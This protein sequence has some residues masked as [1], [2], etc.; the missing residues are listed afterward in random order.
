MNEVLQELKSVQGVSGVLVL[1][2]RSL[3]VHRLLPAYFSFDL[4]KE[5]SWSLKDLV[6]LSQDKINFTF[7]FENGVALV[8]NLEKSVILILAKPS[9]N[10]SILNLVLKSVTPSLEKRLEKE[11]AS[12]IFSTFSQE[13]ES[14]AEPELIK[15]LLKAINLVSSNCQKIIGIYFTTQNLRKAKEELLVSFPF[16]SN[17]YVD[18]NGDVL[19]IKGKEKE[20][21]GD[22][23]AGF[24]FW[25]S[26]FLQYSSKLNSRIAQTDIKDLTFELSEEL[27]QTSFYRLYESSLSQIKEK[28]LQEQ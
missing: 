14:T 21:K 2:K 24:V 25:V 16:I 18:N 27:G 7:S 4:V 5:I 19:I 6:N 26:I 10:H 22:I 20:I 23:L 13:K 12:T 1:D 15:L 8:F 17:F 3:S 9:L 28:Y 11:P